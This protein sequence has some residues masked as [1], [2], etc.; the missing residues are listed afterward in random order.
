MN[1]PGIKHRLFSAFLILSS[2]FVAFRWMPDAGVPYVLAALA[3]IMSLEFYQMMSAA[4][5]SNFNRYGAAGNVLLVFVTWF[6]GVRG[7]GA[8]GSWDSIILFLVTIGIFLRQ[9]PQKENPHPLRTIGGTLFGVLYIGLL[10][11]FLTKLLLFQRPEFVEGI[12]MPGRWLLLYGV[13]AAKAT[14]VGAYLIGCTFGR[15]K[16][17]PRISPGKSWEGVF[18]GILI[19]TLAGAALVWGLR[20]TFATF[21]LTPLRAIPLGIVLSIC[22]VV[23]DLTESLFKRAANVKDSGGVLP[24]MG[25]ILDVL[26]SLLFTFPAI[27]LFLRLVN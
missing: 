4:G 8:E 18:G 10:W 9:F 24:G 11:N 5:V 16:L 25:G 22:A 17:I 23:G 7:G 6:A 15:H 3:A 2:L 26:D 27:Y 12:Y 19:G 14:D 21:G 1:L 20:D 13:I